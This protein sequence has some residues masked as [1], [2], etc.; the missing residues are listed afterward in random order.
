[1]NNKSCFPA[2]MLF[3]MFGNISKMAF[4]GTERKFS[5]V[6]AFVAEKLFTTVST[7]K[8]AFSRHVVTTTTTKPGLLR[9]RSIKFYS[10]QLALI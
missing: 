10:T 6:M 4:A 5:K 8:N 7:V 1:M 2:W 3:W 9:W